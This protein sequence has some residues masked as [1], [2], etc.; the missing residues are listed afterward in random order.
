MAAAAI[1]AATVITVLAS[2]AP[3]SAGPATQAQRQQG[4]QDLA[5]FAQ[6]MRSHGAANFPDPT[7]ANE[8][9]RSMSASSKAAPALQ[10]AQTAC[11]HLL[12]RG[13][14]P[15]QSAAQR[16]AQTAAGLAFARCM[17]SH[18]LTSF[19]DPTPSG[20]ITHEMLANARINLHQP[21][22]LQAADACVAVTHGILTK[23]AVARFAAEQS[24]PSSRASAGPP[25]QT[26]MRQAQHHLVRFAR[27]MRSHGVPSFP[28]P[29]SADAFKRSMSA[30]SKRA[31]ALQSAQ[32]ACQHLLPSG[33]PPRQSAAQRHA[34]TVAGLAFARCMRSHELPN[35][36][37]PSTSGQ[38]T[39]EMLAN[40]GINLHQPAVL[41][42][43]DACVAVTHGILTKAAVA[44]FAA[45]H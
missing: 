27:C 14:P 30:S 32:T 6:C 29:T 8:F 3:S 5:R 41:Q 9:K 10:S 35:F 31:P 21:A 43:A 28:D 24:S 26:Q 1:A 22:V 7:S 37:D 45:G 13:G 12:P 25:T 17:R 15:R 42:A 19:P 34:Q 23:A 44:R 36:P 39:H 16:H 38:I 11:Q 40:A 4:Q 33:G 18:Q 2:S 20:Q